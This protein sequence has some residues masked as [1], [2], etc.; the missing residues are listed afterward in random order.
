MSIAA[1]PSIDPAM[2]LVRLNQRIGKPLAQED[3][4]Q[5]GQQHD[6]DGAADELGQGELPAHQQR[7]KMPSSM[8]RLVEANS[9]AIAAVTFAPL[10]NSDRTRATA[11]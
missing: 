1:W 11:V 9:N 7:Q 6:H 10:R 4:E 5:Q 3:P 8:T 2:P